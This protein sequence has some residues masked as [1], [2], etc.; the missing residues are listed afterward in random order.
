MVSMR[1]F[2]NSKDSEDTI[3]TMELTFCCVL[4]KQ[5]VA[6]GGKPQ[7]LISCTTMH[8]C[9]PCGCHARSSVIHITAIADGGDQERKIVVGFHFSSNYKAHA[10]HNV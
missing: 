9:T 7:N 10:Y 6:H 1:L 2:R 8:G 3:I 4:L 5:S